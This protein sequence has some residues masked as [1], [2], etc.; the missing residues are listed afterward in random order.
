MLKRGRARSAIPRL[1]HEQVVE[2]FVDY[3]FG[4]LSPEMNTAIE[5]HVRSCSRCKREGLTNAANER[6]GAIRQLRS[7]R[8]GKPVLSRR[9]RNILIFLTIIIVVQVVI[10][11]VANGRASA[12]LTLLS[13]GYIGSASIGGNQTPAVKLQSTNAFPLVTSGAS[14]IALSP[15]DKL[16]A[17]AGGDAQRNVTLWDISTQK[18]TNTFTWSDKAP[19]TSIAWSADG[20]RLAAADG[21]QIMIWDVPSGAT[22]WQLGIPSAPAMRVYDVTQQSI[23]SRPDPASAFNSGA[24]AWGA[25]GAL[26]A[27]PTGALGPIGV[28][29]P[30]APVVGMWSSAGS[31]LF[32]GS[33]GKALVGASSTDATRGMALLD[34]SP[35]GRYLLWG[36]LSQPIAVGAAQSSNTA[37]HPPDNV[38]SAL[39]TQIAQAGGGA[40]ALAWFAP[41]GKQVAI[42]DQRT[43]GAHIEIVE[44]A[45]GHVNFQLDESCDGMTTHS[46]LW[47]STGKAFYVVSTKGPVETYP[48]PQ[49]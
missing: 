24:L 26:V 38:I 30:Q 47:S 22:L 48:I 40:S 34:W 41:I 36:A 10:Y 2:S 21:A 46:A 29:T 13:Q 1:R 5:R 12:L 33:G 39:A 15:N 3:H 37:S 9:S 8:G 16:L 28:S 18:V 43:A 20:A 7:V 6:K 42:C 17:V 25:D 4:R 23:V 44:I 27:A 11:Q 14:A 19:P 49:S 35:G 31:H 45:T 32:A